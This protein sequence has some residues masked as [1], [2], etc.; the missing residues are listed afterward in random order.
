M[1]SGN[2]N[3]LGSDGQQIGHS[4]PEIMRITQDP[5]LQFDHNIT[6]S[7]H[8]RMP[9]AMADG[10]HRV[11]ANPGITLMDLPLALSPRGVHTGVGRASPASPIINPNHTVM[12]YPHNPYA[13]LS[14]KDGHVSETGLS[15]PPR[16]TNSKANVA[17]LPDRIHG[18]YGQSSSHLFPL[19]PRPRS[20]LFDPFGVEQQ[21]IR[22]PSPQRAQRLPNNIKIRQ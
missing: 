18:H 7:D 5:P 10:G 13:P 17:I 2:D 4:L 22:T 8:R 15:C 20:R 16:S 12:Q 11:S 1:G 21:A 19:R 14:Q 9:I 3:S 6:S